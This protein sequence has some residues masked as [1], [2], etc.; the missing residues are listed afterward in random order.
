MR[1]REV[2]RVMGEQESALAGASGLC[3]NATLRQCKSGQQ[4]Q[5]WAS[6]G[7]RQTTTQNRVRVVKSVRI[8]DKRKDAR[9]SRECTSVWQ[10][11]CYLW[12]APS[13]RHPEQ[14]THS[15]DPLRRPSTAQSESA[16]A[17]REPAL[18]LSGWESARMA[19]QEVSG[20]TPNPSM[21]GCI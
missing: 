5:T 10:G 13:T 1:I 4:R 7:E 9:K 12:D 15:P 16:A 11:S 6:I 20:R 18:R 2:T 8:S 17:A 14:A 21:S 3:K 19:G